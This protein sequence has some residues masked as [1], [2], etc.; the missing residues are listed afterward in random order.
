M[1]MVDLPARGGLWIQT[2][3]F[4]GLTYVIVKY[5]M[6]GEASGHFL[7][8]RGMDSDPLL[9]FLGNKGPWERG[10]NRCSLLGF[11]DNKGSWKR[12]VIARRG[13]GWGEKKS[14]HLE[15][16]SSNSNLDDTQPQCCP[17]PPVLTSIIRLVP[18]V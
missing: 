18:I 17:N 14:K 8:C 15:D 7:H 6:A 3:D 9:G 4:T 16:M 2:H 12:R 10:W 1:F 13:G 11:L 5:T